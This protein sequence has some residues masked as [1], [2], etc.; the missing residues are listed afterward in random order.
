VKKLFLFFVICSFFLVSCASSLVLSGQDLPALKQLGLLYMDNGE[1]EMALTTLDKALLLDSEDKE[2]LY[3]KI[4][5]L[6]A[7][8]NYQDAVD[9]STSSFEKFPA[10]LRF[11]KAKAS[12]L[13]SL[14]KLE[15][16]LAVYQEMLSLDKGNYELHAQVMEFAMNQGFLEVARS[17]AEFLMGRQKEV[18]RAFA[19]LQRLDGSQSPYAGLETLLE[20]EGN[21]GDGSDENPV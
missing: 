4:L 13:H 7:R 21:P 19:V 8:E 5:V 9:L 17:E 10:A 12:A 3:N 18:S 6:L 14:Q 11:L 2:L 16:A 1:Y 15:Q 20:F